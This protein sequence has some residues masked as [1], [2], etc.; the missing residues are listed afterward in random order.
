MFRHFQ[1]MLKHDK[2]HPKYKTK[3]REN[4]Y[5]ENELQVG[6]SA[7]FAT[8][9]TVD[10]RNFASLSMLFFQ[11]S[12]PSPRTPQRF[13]VVRGDPLST[14]QNIAPT[15][16]S[17]PPRRLDKTT[18]QLGQR[19]FQRSSNIEPLG[20]AGGEVGSHKGVNVERCNF[21]SIN[22]SHFWSNWCRF[23]RNPIRVR[24]V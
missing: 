6:N 9:A 14:G 2:K 4:K 20:G 3:I 17:T 21:S 23:T 1:Q 11:A 12:G 19:N 22:R 10:G 8:S 7:C 24:D 15:A 18:H 16:G 13:N 5:A